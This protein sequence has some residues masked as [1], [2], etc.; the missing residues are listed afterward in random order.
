[1]GFK[2]LFA[3]S[4]MLALGG[5]GLI[6]SWWRQAERELDAALAVIETMRAADTAG[7]A[8]VQGYADTQKGAKDAREKGEKALDALRGADDRAFWD[9]L[10]GLLAPDA[11]SGRHAAGDAAD[12]MR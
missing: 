3:A 1:M 7:R 12:A 4:L 10:G 11:G 9:G 2:L 6:W 5:A 8:A